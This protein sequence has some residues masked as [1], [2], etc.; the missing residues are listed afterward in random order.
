MAPNQS[1]SQVTVFH[2]RVKRFILLWKKL[3]YLRKQQQ[4]QQRIK[5][6]SRKIRKANRRFNRN[7]G[8]TVMASY[9]DK[10]FERAFRMSRSAFNDL[11]LAIGSK[12]M[13]FNA[14]QGK[15]LSC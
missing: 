4:Q 5:I 8:L 2:E 14:I 13:S 9:N 7:Y 10:E 11:E 12:I 3:L 15:K 6:N 1:R